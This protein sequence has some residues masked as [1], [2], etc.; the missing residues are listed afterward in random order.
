MIS[1][2]W[3]QFTPP[4]LTLLDDP[5]TPIRVQ[6][7]QILAIFV[8]HMSSTL[9]QQSGLGELFEDALMPTLMY[10]PNLTPLEE[11]LELLPAAYNALIVLCETRF[12]ASSLPIG[13]GST[14]TALTKPNDK[15]REKF[16]EIKA[17]RLKFLDRIARKGVFMGFAHSME[18]AAIV[19][20]LLNQLRV[21]IDKMGLS[22]V[23]HL[24]VSFFLVH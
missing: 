8:P 18:H 7:A 24:K 21:L 14:T 12:P 22:A 4:L 16:E 9:L 19:E 1:Q 17:S 2:T 23:K 6:G 20:L 13:P 11:S 10:L 5:G 3:H 15:E